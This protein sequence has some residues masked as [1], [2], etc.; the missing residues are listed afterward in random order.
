MNIPCFVAF[1][2][3][4]GGKANWQLSMKRI[5]SITVIRKKNRK[6]GYLIRGLA[7]EKNALL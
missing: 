4:G 3:K 5:S 2:E 7:R 6:I 1:T